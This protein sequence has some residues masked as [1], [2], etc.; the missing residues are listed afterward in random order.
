[1]SQDLCAPYADLF[2]RAA[3]VWGERS[4]LLKLAEECSEL[5]AAL[6]RIVNGKGS[7][8]QVFGEAGDVMLMMGQ[9]Q[10]FVGSD[11]IAEAMAYKAKKVLKRIKEQEITKDGIAS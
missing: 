1:M 11:V 8:D 10:H 5:S 9:L 7:W 2:K 4:Q 6:I 3:V